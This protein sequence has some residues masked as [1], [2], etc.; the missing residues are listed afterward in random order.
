MPGD[1]NRLLVIANPESTG[2]KTGLVQD[3]IQA[4]QD[5]YP[6]DWA[7][8]KTLEDEAASAD[9]LRSSL[10]EGDLVIAAGGDYTVG[11]AASVLTEEEFQGKGIT[12][13][14]LDAGNKNDFATSI[15]NAG[16]ALTT[17]IQYGWTGPVHLIEGEITNDAGDT[18][19]HHAI[20]IAGVG[21]SADISLFSN[22]AAYRETAHTGGLIR[23]TVSDLQVVKGA[24]ERLK[25]FIITTPGSDDPQLRYEVTLTNSR[26]AGGR[27]KP[28]TEASDKR[29][30][31][32]ELD[33]KNPFVVGRL[34]G[35]LILGARPKDKRKYLHPPKELAFTI[36]K[37]AGVMAH[38]DG[39][40]VLDAERKPIR[41]GAGSRFAFR[42]SVSPVQV[43]QM[44]AIDRRPHWR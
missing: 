39:D 30:Y 9:A 12:L 25:P 6:R 38:F 16:H 27:A 34:V 31:R 33:T 10:Q 28:P 2:F 22:E 5:A 20:N 43:R 1:F 4:I 17:I 8:V 18:R 15:G 36:V 3:R 14:P 26:R 11:K 41:F 13:L 19:V 29:F 24:L 40:P 35:G 21:A 32:I 23:K 37:T 7:I 42:H 44:R